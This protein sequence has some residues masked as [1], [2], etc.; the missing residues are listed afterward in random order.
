MSEWLKNLME[1]GIRGSGHLWKDGLELKNGSKKYI[2]IACPQQPRLLNLIVNLPKS[3]K[4][5]GGLNN[6]IV[7]D[8]HLT[9]KRQHHSFILLQL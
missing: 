8:A 2:F 6:H 9:L 1:L 3:P 5:L 4:C 7:H